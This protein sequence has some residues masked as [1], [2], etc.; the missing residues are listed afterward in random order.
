MVPKGNPHEFKMF[1]AARWSKYALP[2]GL[3]SGEW[4]FIHGGY[5]TAFAQANPNVVFPL[6]ALR[7][8]AGNVYGELARDFY[9]ITGVGTSLTM[10]QRAGE[11]IAASMRELRVDAALLVAT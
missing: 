6:D 10:A 11:E 5:N 7:E 1:N 9:S 8:Y 2:D 3:Q 4:E